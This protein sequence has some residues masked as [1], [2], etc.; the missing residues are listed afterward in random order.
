MSTLAYEIESEEQPAPRRWTREEYYLMAETGVL[1]PEDNVELI[2]GEIVYKVSPQ[3]S[4]HA[5]TVQLVQQ[6]LMASFG[7][8]YHVRTQ[9]P[10]SVEGDSDPEPDAVLSK[11]SAR[12]F[13]AT[14]PTPADVI[15]VVEVSDSSISFDRGR[16]ARLYARAGIADYWIVNLV[17]RHVEV[18]TNPVEGLGYRSITL[19]REGDSIQPPVLG[20][21]PIAVGD[22]L[23]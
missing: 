2:E 19:Y 18:M 13:L 21:L 10:I 6:A 17:N 1:G 23:P 5:V 14:H 4:P 11:G 8:E 15:L 12:R 7:S 9:L 3:K 20:A 16:K 22:L